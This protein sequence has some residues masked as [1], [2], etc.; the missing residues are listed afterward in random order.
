MTENRKRINKITIIALCTS[1]ALLLS[2]V[3]MLIP[4]LIQGVPGIKMG[5]PNIA[6]IFALYTLGAKKTIFISFARVAIMS[7]LFGNI[8]YFL[9]SIVGAVF[10]LAVM[11]IL[12]K[13]DFMS[14][15]GVSVA[16][17]LAHNI[18]QILVAMLLTSI[19]IFFIAAIGACGASGVAG[20]SLLLIPLA[21]S[22]FGIT[23]DVAMQVVAVGFIIGVIQDSCETALNS[24]S[25]AIFTATAE[26]RKWKKEGRK[27]E[28]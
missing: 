4:V 22:L 19:G 26:F 14:S 1:L 5:L 6:I 17:A 3:E 24:S 25:D 20:G 2:Y 10:S 12:R 18:G 21:C 8:T 9:Y 15:V 28:W 11:I 7:L 27:I 16:G 13:L 23:N